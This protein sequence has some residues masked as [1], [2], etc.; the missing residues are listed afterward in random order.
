[1]EEKLSQY[2][3]WAGVTQAEMARTMGIPLRTYEDLESEKAKFRPVHANAARW[4]L[5]EIAAKNDDVSRL[6][7]GISALVFKVGKLLEN[8]KGGH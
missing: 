1:M 7:A 5:L 8:K 2:R 3:Q 6:P 4:A